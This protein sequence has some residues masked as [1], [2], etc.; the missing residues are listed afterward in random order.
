MSEQHWIKTL[1]L[2]TN[3][4]IERRKTCGKYVVDVIQSILLVGC[5]HLSET[6]PRKKGPNTQQESLINSAIRLSF[7]IPKSE[8]SYLLA[9]FTS[10]DLCR[11]CSNEIG[12][13][14]Q[15]RRPSRAAKK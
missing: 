6:V 2:Q 15:S 5:G 1:V 9:K 11:I 8:W 10:L 13:V 7:T 3:L 12:N 14:H 4:F